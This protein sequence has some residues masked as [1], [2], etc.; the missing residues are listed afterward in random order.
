MGFY[1]DPQSYTASD[2]TITP[3]GSLQEY[4][5]GIGMRSRYLDPQSPY[6][7]QGI[8]STTPNVNQVNFI[9]E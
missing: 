4:Q 9:A 3:L 2:T 1:Q 6:Y 8:A 7:I 5:S